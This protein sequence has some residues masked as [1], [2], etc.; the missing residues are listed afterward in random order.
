VAATVGTFTLYLQFPGSAGMY[1]TGQTF[2]YTQPTSASPSPSS[3]IPVTHSTPTVDNNSASVV[4]NSAG[5]SQGGSGQDTASLSSK[6]VQNGYQS[7]GSGGSSNSAVVGIAVGV[8]LGGLLIISLVTVIILL[9]WKRRRNEHHNNS[10]FR[11][12]FYLI[13]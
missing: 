3:T 7:P 9:L 6:S 10:E 5:S 2:T 4:I 8:T 1:D 11:S 12:V 13:A